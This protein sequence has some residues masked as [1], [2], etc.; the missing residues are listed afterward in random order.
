[1]TESD[2][3]VVHVQTTP[4][5][6]IAFRRN[7]HNTAEF[8]KYRVLTALAI[9]IVG[10]AFILGPNLLSEH[11]GLEWSTALVLSVVVGVLP[12]YFVQYFAARRNFNRAHDPKGLFLRRHQI[13]ASLQGV[14]FKSDVADLRYDWQAF[15]RFEET[16]THF[17]LY[18][19]TLMAYIIPKRDF[20]SVEDINR[21]GA[22]VRAHI[23]P[24]Q[25]SA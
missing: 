21:F 3:V 4:D 23:K 24:A 11:L 1:M 18:A 16:P 7:V 22:V 6:S 20:K 13:S 10:L 12:L 2:T 5:D 25:S 17:F 19:D 9:V 15:I 14:S 8:R